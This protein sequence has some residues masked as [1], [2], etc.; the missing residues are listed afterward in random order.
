M[1]FFDAEVHALSV[2]GVDSDQARA[3]FERLRDAAHAGSDLAT[4][5]DIVSG[6]RDPGLNSVLTHGGFNLDESSW[7]Q[8]QAWMDGDPSGDL[9]A[10][11]T[12]TFALFR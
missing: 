11:S 4:A 5:R 1:S 7:A 8:F 10:L 9:D 6:Q 12:P 2:A 3:G